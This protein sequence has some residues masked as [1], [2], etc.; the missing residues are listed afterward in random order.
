M[1]DWFWIYNTMKKNYLLET[2]II[3]TVFILLNLYLVLTSNRVY[4]YSVDIVR[5]PAE[6]FFT[7][8]G[9]Y[10]QG[11]ET[12]HWKES[13]I[14]VRI[15]GGLPQ[16][17]QNETIVHELGHIVFTRDF[18]PRE[19][20]MFTQIYKKNKGRGCGN[21]YGKTSD[22]ECWAE[23]STLMFFEKTPVRTDLLYT[24][25]SSLMVK[26]KQKYLDILN[27]QNK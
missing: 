15:N 24:Y 19:R 2:I 25:T 1:P 20:R 14:L 10:M 18:T 13:N 5:E 8:P 27:A 12:S 7:L 11:G 6:N 3:L 4:A 16:S 26:Y 9:G 23:L 21:E 17:M 22:F